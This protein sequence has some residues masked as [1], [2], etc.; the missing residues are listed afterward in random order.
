[1]SVAYIY[2]RSHPS[3]DVHNACKLGKTNNITEKR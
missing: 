3:Y 2:I 1:M